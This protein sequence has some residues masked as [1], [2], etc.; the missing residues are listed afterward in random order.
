MI[1]FKGD[2]FPDYSEESF[3]NY[4][5]T[6]AQIVSVKETSKACRKIYEY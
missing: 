5:S 2:I 4:L 6:A 3:K 1:T